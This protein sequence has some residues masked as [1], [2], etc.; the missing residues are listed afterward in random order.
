MPIYEYVCLDCEEN[1]ELLIMRS[2][3][4]PECVKCGSKRLEKRT[5]A[6][7]R[8]GGGSGGLS[9]GACGPSGGFS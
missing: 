2:D 4:E 3:E 5:S 6:F 8:V 1:F 7:A 9:A